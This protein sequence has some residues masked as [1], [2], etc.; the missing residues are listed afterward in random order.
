M[1]V[2]TKGGDGGETSL[3][4]GE[5]V[6]KDDAL[7]EAVGTGDELVSHLGELR[8]RCVEHADT[9]LRVQKTIFTLNAHVATKGEQRE[10]FSVSESDISFLEEK[11]AEFEEFYGELKAFIIPS[12][13]LKASK[14]D[15]CRTVARRYERRLITV[16]GYDNFNPAVRKYVNRLSDMLFMLARVL[17]K[18]EE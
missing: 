8:L 9:I 2:T 18:E 6:R 15:I 7:M 4:S 1:S 5:R 11:T 12:G 13:N 10:K 17:E 16:S 14:A 3:Y